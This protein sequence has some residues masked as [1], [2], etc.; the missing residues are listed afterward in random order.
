MSRPVCRLVR[1]LGG[2]QLRPR[3][4]AGG[5]ELLTV[6]AACTGAEPAQLAGNFDR[7]GELKVAVADVATLA[8]VRKRYDEL[9]RDPA[10]VRA[11]L[12]DGASCASAQARER[13]AAAKSA[14]GLL[15]I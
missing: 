2:G 6:L 5:V 12:R 15:P 14:I 11:V 13:V 10:H 4:Q 1:R 7:Y 9:S 3:P 8:P